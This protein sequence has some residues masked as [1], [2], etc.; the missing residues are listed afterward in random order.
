MM[1]RTGINFDGTWFEADYE[2]I[3]SQP[4]SYFQEG[5]EPFRRLGNVYYKGMDVTEL[6]QDLSIYEQLQDI[7]N[8]E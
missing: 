3:E 2:Y 5:I 8:N 6:T 4:R 1:P 7:L